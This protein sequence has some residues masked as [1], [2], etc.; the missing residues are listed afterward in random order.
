MGKKPA[1]SR[2]LYGW[3]SDIYHE[4]DERGPKGERAKARWI[5]CGYS[6]VEFQ[7][8]DKTASPSVDMMAWRVLIAILV[9]MRKCVR[10]DW[11]F[12][13]TTAY[14]WA[15]KDRKFQT[16]MQQAKGYEEPNSEGMC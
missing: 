10:V 13:V 4:G 11:V 7:D 9:V 2:M 8:Y 12:D 6:M 14:L 3:K 5:I 16:F 15:M 1:K